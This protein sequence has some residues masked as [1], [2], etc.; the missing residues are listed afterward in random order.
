MV[1][2]ITVAGVNQQSGPGIFGQLTLPGVGGG[3]ATSPVKIMLYANAA[4]GSIANTAATAGYTVYGPT[5]LVPLNTVND[6][7]AIAGTNSPAYLGYQWIRKLNPTVPVSFTPVEIVASGTA[8]SQTIT[9]TAAGSPT[10]TTG[11]I[12]YNVDGQFVQSSFL[13]GSS[14]DSATTV[15]TKLAA[16]I[17]ANQ[18]LPVTASSSGAV[19]TV[20]AVVKNQRSNWL[21]G[22]AQ[23]L[24]GAGVTVSVT[25]PTFFTGGLGS[26]ASYLQSVLNSAAATSNNFYYNV[27]EAGF[28]SVDGYN[29]VLGTFS[30]GC[31]AYA[32]QFIDATALPSV[33]NRQRAIFGSVDTLS[34]T[35]HT[36][37][38][39]DDIRLEGICLPNY[40]RTPFELACIFAAGIVANETTPITA[41][42]MNY[43]N[44]GADQA[45]A[46]F[47]PVAA[48]LDGSAPSHAQ[49]AAAAI[50]GVSGVQVI[51]GTQKTSVF[52][53]VTSYFYP[54]SNTAVLD[55]RVQ[56][57]CDVTVND[58]FLS[59]LQNAVAV[60][61]VRQ[62]IGVDPPS[63]SSPAIPGVMTP[64][65]VLDIVQEQ[66][67]EYAAS[68]CINGQQ[69][70]GSIV[71]QNNTVNNTSIGISYTLYTSNL[72]HQVLINGSGLPAL[73]VSS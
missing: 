13:G 6:M 73:V 46:P 10:Q 20:T 41:N 19:V 65:Q 68:G 59:S 2:D 56:D 9:I 42:G 64:D 60:R 8:S 45:S 66:V 51:S 58:R 52:Q 1:S 37:L 3:A 48:P 7:A 18:F 44:W 69:T 35:E 15:A 57:A 25:T 26:D 54:P 33:G 40:D 36:A 28:D 72:L 53:R 30:T 62:V 11:T 31:V 50:S 63:G 29:S 17:N 24:G 38:D 4:P 21:R 34:A 5:T 39:V 49:L 27:F 43:D 70:L 71:V 12:Q 47:W 61:A 23:V 55:L 32:Q 67:N 16:A 14:P 22:F